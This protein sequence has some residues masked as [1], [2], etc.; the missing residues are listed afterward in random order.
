MLVLRFLSMYKVTA[1]AICGWMR[2]ARENGKLHI[3][4]TELSY[5][6][7]IWMDQN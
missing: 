2:S 7:V 1:W 5:S 6:Y 3:T 4:G